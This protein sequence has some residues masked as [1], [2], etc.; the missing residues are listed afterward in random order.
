MIFKLED[1]KNSDDK[2]YCMHCETLDEAESFCNF[3]HSQGRK[4]RGGTS[5]LPEDVWRY[6]REDTV[7]YFNVGTLGSYK[8]AKT[9][10]LPK[11]IILE[12]S[13]FMED[14]MKTKDKNKGFIKEIFEMLGIEPN[15]PFKIKEDTYKLYYK[16]TKELEVIVSQDIDFK[17]KRFSGYY[18]FYSFVFGEATIVKIPKI[19]KKEQM[20]IDYARACGAKWLSKDPGGNIYAY[21][22]KPH[23][24]KDGIWWPVEDEENCFE[25]VMDLA[26]LSTMDEPYYIGDENE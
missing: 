22:K 23:R 5:Y 12:W 13:D 9:Y 16:L 4:W 18:T 15:E 7:Y 10:K 17:G 19:T 21:S 11:V 1:Y 6:N 2:T 24:A 25:I 14:T 26:F 8:K 3:L 20:A